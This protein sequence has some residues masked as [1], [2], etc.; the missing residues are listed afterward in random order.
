[1][2]IYSGM[3][4]SSLVHYYLFLVVEIFI[5]FSKQMSIFLYFLASVAVLY[6]FWV[7]RKGKNVEN[8]LISEKLRLFNQ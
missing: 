4:L 6:I 2:A 7:Y 1:M 8:I 5:V 3:V